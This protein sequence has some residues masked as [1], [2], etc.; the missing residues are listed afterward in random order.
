MARTITIELSDEQYAALE[1]RARERG[2]TV[3]AV[4]ADQM[5]PSAPTESD[6]LERKR[7]ALERLNRI[8]EQQPYTDLTALLFESREEL[9]ARHFS[10]L[11]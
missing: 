10:P 6:D 3:E 11:P 8:S 5:P 7:A 1:A 2:T 9:E 4:V